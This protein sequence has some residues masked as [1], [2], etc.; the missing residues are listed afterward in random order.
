MAEQAGS[1][2]LL[3]IV[4]SAR[5]QLEYKLGQ[6]AVAAMSEKIA[7]RYGY[8]RGAPDSVTVSHSNLANYLLNSH[9]DPRDIL[10]HH[11]AAALVSAA[12]G[13]RLTERIA[14]LAKQLRGLAA[15]Q[16]QD[17]LPRDFPALCDT[18]EQVEGVRFREMVEKLLPAGT[19]GDDL[20]QSALTQAVDLVEAASKAT[21]W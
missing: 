18:V 17:V 13:V 20:L 3:G 11:L 1:L 16:T 2:D 10:A 9:A 12:T 15:A 4:F 21:S 14:I 5:A 19:S 7:L 6:P 8:A